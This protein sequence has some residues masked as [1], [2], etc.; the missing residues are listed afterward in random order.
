MTREEQIQ[1]DLE[2]VQQD[3]WWA[4]QFV[5]EQTPEICMI[6]VKQNG[7]A[8]RYVE[9]QTPEICMAAVQQN[10]LAL[11]Y[12]KEQTPEICMAAVQRNGYALRYVKE[13]TP[14]LCAEA[15]KNDSDA[16]GLVAEDLKEEVKALLNNENSLEEKKQNPMNND[17]QQEVWFKNKITGEKIVLEDFVEFVWEEAERQF[18]EC[19]ENGNWCDLTRGEQIHTYCEQYM[20]Q[21]NNGDWC[22]EDKREQENKIRLDLGFATLVVEKGVDPNFKEVFVGL[23]DKDGV[24]IQDLAVIGRKYHCQKGNFVYEDEISLKV[25]ADKY[26]EDYTHE[27]NVGVYEEA[28][29]DLETAK[30]LV[31]QME[32]AKV[33]KM[34]M[35]KESEQ[36]DRKQNKEEE[37]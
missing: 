36:Q 3:G 14:E 23:E 16:W 13:Q 21:L 31:H 7:W 37:R 24:W 1:K 15:V 9:E 22:Q 28:K 11:K 19:H 35:E 26:D 20:H 8:L 18:N 4:L 10:G 32:A 34:D 12:V 2:M 6:A 17:G 27:F 5:K 25:Y 29:E 30:S 33:Q